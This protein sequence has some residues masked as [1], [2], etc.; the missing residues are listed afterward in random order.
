[1]K[2]KRFSIRLK[3]LLIFGPLTIIAL[4]VLGLLSVRI[5]QKAVTEKVTVHLIDKAN[6][7]AEII[8]G[9]VT[10][11][12]QFLTGIA[13]MP[14][15]RTASASTQEKIAFLKYEIALNNEIVALGIADLDGNLHIDEQTTI[16]VQNNVWYIEALRGNNFL[17][18]PF[19]SELNDQI[20]VSF[21]VPIYDDAHRLS[22]V[23]VADLHGLWLSNSIKDIVVGKT[24]YCYIIGGTGTVTAHPD[25]E[26][27]R[28]FQNAQRLA[29]TDDAFL[30]RATFEKEAKQ[31]T[32][33][34]VGYYEWEG[35]SNIASFAQIPGTMRTVI[36]KAPIAEFMGA[37]QQLRV[38]IYV[39]GIIILLAVLTVTGIAA[40][41]IVKPINE[42]VGSL[43]DIAEGEGDLTVRLGERG[44]DEIAELSRYFNRTI[45]KIGESVRSVGASTEEMRGI[46]EELSS[47]MTETA[48]AVNE[49]SA[50]IEGVKQQA[51]T[52]A[53][54]VG[55]TAA[56]VEEIIRT[57]RQL[58]GSIEQ[59]AAS[60]AESSAAIEEMVSN[61]ASI[62]ATLEK[63][64]AVVKLLAGATEDG[65]R[66]VA[67]SGDV[68]RRI[69]EESGGLLEASSVI[70]HIASQT[71]LL[72]MNAAI[73]AAHAGEAG[74]GFAVVADEIRKLAE[75]SSVQ[76]KTITATLKTL[77]GEIE[78]LS[79]SARRAEEK[80]NAIFELTGQVKDMSARVMEA[81]QE[82]EHG[83][84]EVLVAIKDINDVTQQVSDGSAEM[85]RGSEDVA[86]EMERLDELT[87]VITGS[88]NEM[89]A[90]ATQINNAVQE[91]NEIAHSNREHIERLA[92]EVGKFKV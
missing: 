66:T 6:D 29:Q 47:S 86:K 25:V 22:A 45:E 82:Q 43:R 78:A 67:A 70:Q 91:V 35:V 72:A 39:V 8:N 38:S 85:L 27:V 13:S 42:V 7:T 34:S 89:A 21:A 30:S 62:T 88:M 52:Q 77:S 36:I 73:E 80:F 23:L 24:G 26:L 63:S 71:N 14:L 12:F 79:E 54:G 3:L 49:I 50:N 83:S 10:A 48:S 57:I 11:I 76:G 33:S 60:V 31:N 41:T 84:R 40:H 51:V 61:I 75:E 16:N 4:L 64:D 92:G 81:M 87:R 28:N 18:E 59:Q 90:G 68:T 58:N 53:A 9:K 5:A 2:Q 17:T 37:V 69:A 44:N 56:T 15:L 1:M 20:I 65:S 32:V 74:K 19:L 46:G 55:E